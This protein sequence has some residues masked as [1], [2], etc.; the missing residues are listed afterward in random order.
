MDVYSTAFN[1]YEDD[2]IVV[3]CS[4]EQ[5]TCMIQKENEKFSYFD[6]QGPPS[7]SVSVQMNKL[8][9]ESY[10]F[11]AL[12]E[13]IL[14]DLAISSSYKIKLMP[15]SESEYLHAHIA[16]IPIFE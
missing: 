14:T 7:D 3:G 13:A 10:V 5:L 6:N 16:D 1:I 11:F 4:W 2:R 9:D 12:I 15:I 8:S